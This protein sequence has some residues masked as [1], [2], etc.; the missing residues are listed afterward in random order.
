MTDPITRLN[1]ALEGHHAVER[2]KN[3]EVVRWLFDDTTYGTFPRPIVATQI[4]HA[5]HAH[6]P[7]DRSHETR[8]SPSYHARS[9]PRRLLA[10]DR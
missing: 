2:Q 4:R 3:R 8:R 6:C 10:D 7:R 1:A 5:H 9:E